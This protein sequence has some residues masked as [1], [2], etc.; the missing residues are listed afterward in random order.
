HRD[1]AQRLQVRHP[2]PDPVA[3][4]DCGDLLWRDT[5]NEQS[6]EAAHAEPDRADLLARHGT[7]LREIFGRALRIFRRGVRLEEFHHQLLRLVG[8]TDLGALPVI[9][10]RRERDKAFAGEHVSDTLYLVG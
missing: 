6:E 7:V 1:P 4:D 10:I 8:L 5:P 3:V 2:L 9:E